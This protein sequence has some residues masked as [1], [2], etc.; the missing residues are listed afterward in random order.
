MERGL[1]RSADGEEKENT[2]EHLPVPLFPLYEEEGLFF[3]AEEG[4][5]SPSPPPAP[6]KPQRPAYVDTE[7][8]VP[9]WKS[10]RVNKE[11]FVEWC[12]KVVA[13]ADRPDPDA[14]T[15]EEIR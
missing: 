13:H 5:K 2:C 10:S 1:K 14:P 9:D 4:K 8:H 3:F 15:V 12:R 6:R 7:V 11:E